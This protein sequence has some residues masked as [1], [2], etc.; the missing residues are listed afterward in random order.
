[1]IKSISEFKPYLNTLNGDRLQD[2]TMQDFEEETEKMRFLKAIDLENKKNKSK[3]VELLG[4]VKTYMI[5]EYENETIN[6]NQFENI[7]YNEIPNLVTPND[8][9]WDFY[10]VDSHLYN[11][12]Y[13]FKKWHYIYSNNS[14]DKN[15]LIELIKKECA[16]MPRVSNIRDLPKWSRLLRMIFDDCIEV[17]KI[18]NNYEPLY[19]K[20]SDMFSRKPKKYI[21]E[22]STDCRDMLTAS[23]STNFTSCFNIRKGGSNRCSVNYLTIDNNTL[24]AKVYT[25]D[26]DNLKAM[27]SGIMPYDRAVA[28]RFISL[29]TDNNFES[30]ILGRAYPDDTILS[31][32]DL[33]TIL[34]YKLLNLNISTNIR[35]TTSGGVNYGRNY[36]GYA[37][38]NC[39]RTHFYTFNTSNFRMKV[40]NKG[41]IIY[42]PITDK[43]VV[44]TDYKLIPSSICLLS[45]S[46][47]SNMGLDDGAVNISRNTNV[48]NRGITDRLVESLID[49]TNTAF[50]AF[51][52]LRYINPINLTRPTNEE[53]IVSM[54]PNTVTTTVHSLSSGFGGIH[55]IMAEPIDEPF[56]LD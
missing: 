17:F 4:G 46:D 52:Y 45:E 9:G 44:T 47:Y 38:Y 40:G 21:L 29:D 42:N 50:D 30:M 31:Q 54:Y 51:E 36:S 48:E 13:R 24:V 43:Y 25:Y 8:T 22:L 55:T 14:I 27:E 28:R 26:D 3:L 19:A 15:K 23:V 18:T 1:M 34:E 12:L 10:S 2:I 53:E 56:G 16:F 32:S 49:E 11:M 7:I 35:H 6:Y 39:S 37:D 41:A 20:L 33:A 5:I